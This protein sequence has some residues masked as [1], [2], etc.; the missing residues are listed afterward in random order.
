MTLKI[1]GGL[2]KGI[3]LESPSGNKTRPTSSMLREAV[4]NICQH[5][6]QEANFLDI[7]A[8]TGAMGLEAL[9]RGAAHSTFIENDRNALACIRKN[10]QKLSATDKTSILPIDVL[11]SLKKL[12][13]QT[14]DLIY[15]DPPYG[16]K[17][18]EKRS[19]EQLKAILA[20]LDKHLTDAST[21]IF[22]EFSSYCKEDFSQLPF[23]RIRWEQ[24]RTFARSDLHLFK[25]IS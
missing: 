21:W 9:S 16:E 13:G 4:F 25:R 6:V 20:H 5:K 12:E 18:I 24:K 1:N 11:S 15:I 23:E 3:S 17:E 8:G 10:I 14:F 2:F 19:L 7:F 22:V